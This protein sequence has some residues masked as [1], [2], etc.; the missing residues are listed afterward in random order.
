MI[1]DVVINPSAF[2]RKAYCHLRLPLR[3]SVFTFYTRT[4]TE[5]KIY[6]IGMMCLLN[7]CCC[8]KTFISFC[9]GQTIH[10]DAYQQKTVWIYWVHRCYTSI[11]NI[12]SSTAAPTGRCGSWRALC[13]HMNRWMEE[14]TGESIDRQRL[15]SWRA[16]CT[17]RKPF[18]TGLDKGIDRQINIRVVKQRRVMCPSFYPCSY[19]LYSAVGNKCYK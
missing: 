2:R 11:S 6:E 4:P 12:S 7:L 9:L 13:I 10:R 3:I 19:D 5:G 18:W 16:L 1:V 14:W 15:F 17:H 8:F